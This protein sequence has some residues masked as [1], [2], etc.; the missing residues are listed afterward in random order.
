MPGFLKVFDKN[1]DYLWPI[2]NTEI[3]LNP[4]LTQ[5]PNW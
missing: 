5:N 4:Q 3:Q 1:R 2:P